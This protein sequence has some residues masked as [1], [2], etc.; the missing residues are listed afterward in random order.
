MCLSFYHIG[1]YIYTSSLK[2][3]VETLTSPLI[4]TQHNLKCVRLWYFLSNGKSY[5]SEIKVRLVAG[6]LTALLW[7]S[8][9]EITTWQYVQLPLTYRTDFQ[10]RLKYSRFFT[11]DICSGMYFEVTRS[12]VVVCLTQSN[13][14]VRVRS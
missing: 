10:V 4:S 6:N 3:A 8:S 12:L 14:E 5:G 2:T 11:T 9:T 7:R 13:W 1:D